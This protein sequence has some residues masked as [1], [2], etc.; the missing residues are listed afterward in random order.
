MKIQ[1]NSD[2]NKFEK[3]DQME[4]KVEKWELEMAK[5]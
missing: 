2:G 1:Q 3:W 5:K 4:K